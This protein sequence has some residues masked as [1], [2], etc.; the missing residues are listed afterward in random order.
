MNWNIPVT[1]R[2]KGSKHWDLNEIGQKV[3][4]VAININIRKTI[5]TRLRWREKV[6]MFP[7]VHMFPLCSV[8]CLDVRVTAKVTDSK[9]L[10]DRDRLTLFSTRG[11]IK[12]W[13][14]L[15]REHQCFNLTQIRS[16]LYSFRL[17]KSLME[18]FVIVIWSILP[19]KSI[20]E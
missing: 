20:L 13:W 10:V 12:Y 16:L 6:E 5:V 7:H 17:K 19:I 9:R 8:K 4:E 11:D 2:L 15:K 1:A 14:R 18:I 3:P